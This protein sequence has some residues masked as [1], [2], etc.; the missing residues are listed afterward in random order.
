MG[1]RGAAP[2]LDAFSAAPGG[3]RPVT[4]WRWGRTA[5]EDEKWGPPSQGA[6]LICGIGPVP[7]TSQTV[8]QKALALSFGHLL[9]GAKCAERVDNEV[10]D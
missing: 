10:L 7:G 9:P 6:E 2:R 1:R 8:Q 4:E 3:G 5:G